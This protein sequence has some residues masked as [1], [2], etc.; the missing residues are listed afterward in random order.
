MTARKYEDISSCCRTSKPDWRPRLYSTT[1]PGD[2]GHQWYL[3]KFIMP[4]QAGAE[5]ETRFIPA[6]VTDN[7][8]SN[9]CLTLST[10][11]TARAMSSRPIS[12][13][14]G[15]GAMT[16]WMP[17]DTWSPLVRLAFTSKNSPACEQRHRQ[18]KTPCP[19]KPAAKSGQER[20]RTAKTGQTTPSPQSRSSAVPSRIPVVLV[21]FAHS[22][23]VKA[24]KTLPDGPQCPVN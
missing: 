19:P 11:P 17:S 3:D 2:I 4:H 9:P 8:F 10:T 20:P 14:K 16:L 12:T 5:T 22:G 7:A 1:N 21:S 13:K 23:I 24:G 18:P 15:K 6:R